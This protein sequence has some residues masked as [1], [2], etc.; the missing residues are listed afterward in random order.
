M[1]TKIVI[2]SG[3]LFAAILFTGIA[4]SF[5]FPGL[6]CP[7]G[8]IV[9]NDV[10]VI[11]STDSRE[12]A[13]S[14]LTNTVTSNE[15]SS[16]S[17]TIFV[18]ALL[19]LTGDRS[20]RGEDYKIAIH[21]AEQDFN[22]YLDEL[23]ANWTLDIIIEDSATSPVIALEKLS[24]LNAKN[25][26]IVI[27][28]QSSA[29]LRNVMSYADYNGMLLVSSG[30]TAPTL[31]IPNDNVYRFIPDDSTQGHVLARLIFDEGITIVVPIWRGDAWGDG[32][33]SVFVE[34]FT[35]LG[36]DIDEGIRYNPESVEFSVSTSLLAEKIQKYS[37][38]TSLEEIAVLDMS[39]TEVVQ[40]MQSSS[41]YDILDDVRWF[42]ASAIVKDNQLVEDRIA[43]KF[44]EDVKFVAMQF[45][46][47]KTI[48]YDEVQN[49]MESE[50][51]RIPNAYAFSTYD[52]VWIIGLAILQTQSTE[53][54][55]IKEIIPSIAE[56]YSGVIGSTRLN[57]A[58]DLDNSN[59]E[60]WGI[61]NSKWVLVGTYNS[62]T[63]SILK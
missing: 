27:G 59:Y 55:V 52:S 16:L 31:A 58:G 51:G 61:E 50:L 33:Q 3:I 8:T 21:L 46:P 10:C 37:E 24:S 56:D 54:S 9:K 44:S 14:E 15:K 30:S 41:Q 38:Y 62:D 53:M 25:I 5:M 23:D 45:A 20:T 11:A 48:K 4:S 6:T 36:G 34:E 26:H 13:K 28:P 17:E 47:S 7:A 32:L 35:K 18:G 19:P 2:V 57:D 43:Q 29:E 63:D 60:L 12:G 40:I 22:N 1:K 42:G 49:L 39:F